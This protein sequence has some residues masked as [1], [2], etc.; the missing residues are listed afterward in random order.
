VTEHV[1]DLA[2]G[3]MQ[4]QLKETSK[5]FVTYSIARDDNTDIKGTVGFSCFIRGVNED[6]QLME[7]LLELVPLKQKE[8]LVQFFLKG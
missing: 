8:M 7:E 4:C 3:Y 1:N 6:F 5:N 2:R